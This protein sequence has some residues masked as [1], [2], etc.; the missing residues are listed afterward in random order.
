MKLF[1]IQLLKD[2]DVSGFRTQNAWSKEA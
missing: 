1:L 2:H